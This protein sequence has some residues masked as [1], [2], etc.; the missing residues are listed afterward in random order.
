[1]TVNLQ[2][3]FN[4]F[5]QPLLVRWP[6]G[7]HRIKNREEGVAPDSWSEGNANVEKNVSGLLRLLDDD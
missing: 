5:V 1:M 6:H 7:P 2:N 4:I 3:A